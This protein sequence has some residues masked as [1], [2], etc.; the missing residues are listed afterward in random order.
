MA[1]AREIYGEQPG[2]FESSSFCEEFRKSLFN[3]P[4]PCV[5]HLYKKFVVRLKRHSP[6]LTVMVIF[7]FVFMIVQATLLLR[8]LCSIL[9]Q[10]ARR[11]NSQID[12]NFLFEFVGRMMPLLG[13]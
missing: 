5:R 11:F 12:V 4:P 3:K 2:E 8:W 7:W 9:F 1:F 6:Q 10:R 13:P